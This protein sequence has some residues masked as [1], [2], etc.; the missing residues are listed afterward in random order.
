MNKQEYQSKYTSRQFEKFIVNS[1]DGNK[2]IGEIYEG[3]IE[4]L[5]KYAG[6]LVLVE[7]IEGH[8]INHLSSSQEKSEDFIWRK[9]VRLGVISKKPKIDLQFGQISLTDKA[10][11][12]ETE[13]LNPYPDRI[14]NLKKEE[15]V[16]LRWYDFSKINQPI[17]KIN[18]M[19]TGII[20]P[21]IKIFFGNKEIKQRLQNYPFNFDHIKYFP[22]NI[23]NCLKD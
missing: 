11:S 20:I 6:E 16:S 1:H 13:D 14:K 3:L 17:E 4:N 23:I 21:K 18:P 8:K 19:A 9:K 2:K 5:K 7:T 12:F 10:I 22:Q 15:S